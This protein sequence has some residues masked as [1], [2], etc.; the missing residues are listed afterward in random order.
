MVASRDLIEEARSHHLAGRLED[1]QRLYEQILEVEPNNATALS[2]YGT[3]LAQRGETEEALNYLKM[4]IEAD[5]ESAAHHNN[6]GVVYQDRGEFELALEHFERSQAAQ[7]GFV[8]PIYNAAKLY[9]QRGQLDEAVTTY[10]RLLDFDPGH[11]E[12]LINLGNIYFESGRPEESVAY[13]ERALTGNPTSDVTARIQL[14]LGNAYRRMGDDAAAMGA[15]EHVLKSAPHDGLR[16]KSALTLPVVLDSWEHIHEVR[17]GFERRVKELLDSDIAITDPALETSTTTFFL[18]Y[19]GLADRKLQEMVAALHLKAC[20]G[21]AMVAPHC[22]VP[23]KPKGKIKLGLVSAYF[24]LHSIGRL[25]RGIVEHLDRDLFEVTLFTQP[26]HSDEI[27][28]FIEAN[29][30]RCIV[31]PTGL[32]EA[33]EAISITGQDIL[34][35]ADIGMDIRTYFMAFARLA[36]VQCVTWG[37][38]DTTGIPNIDYFLSSDL[39]ERDGAAADYSETLHLLDTLPTMY[40]MPV[41]PAALISRNELGIESKKTIYFCPQS[42]IKHHPDMDELVATIL[43]GDEDGEVYFLEGAVSHWSQKLTERMTRRLPDVA[44][45]VRIIPRVSPSDFLSLMRS[46][47]VI[48]DTP[49]FSGGNTSY[50]AFAMGTP[51]VA[52]A[53]EFMRGRV[54]TAQYKMM[55]IDELTAEDVPGMAEVALR[56]GRDEAYRS[57]MVDRITLRRDV[58][59]GELE[60]VRELERFFQQSVANIKD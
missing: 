2:L 55:Q 45:R 16:I 29:A 28:S 10:E 14:N 49:H 46:A 13:Y 50:E 57:E 40:D 31:L 24:R 25:M 6:I 9:K 27:S 18:A 54:T 48:L 39:M 41:P 37:H 58:L 4:A 11:A 59:F 43:R 44:G 12:A 17:A 52:H 3:L 35:Y 30:D 8:D 15:F 47:D 51:I 26:G 22:E 42:A 56:L 23:R 20:P 36:P 53:G 60:A 38:P 1:A 21:L 5:P 7:P 33:R 19:H 32:W 34:F